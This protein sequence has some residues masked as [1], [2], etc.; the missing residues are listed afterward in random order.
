MHK[1]KKMKNKLLLLLVLFNLIVISCKKETKNEATQTPKIEENK[2][3]NVT[4]NL[5]VTVDDN[6]QIYYIED[7]S[8]IFTPDK[9]IDVS[10][11][12][13]NTPQEINFKLPE[14]VVP[15]NLR[16]DLGTN[17]Q[18]KEV[19]II[20]F[21]LKYYDKSF[22]SKDTMFVYYFW[23]NDQII[24]D[25]KKATATPKI[26]TNGNYDPIFVATDMLKKEILKLTK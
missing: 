8:N 14:D 11:K 17:K 18:Q 24:Y 16:F 2:S 20:D 15:T 1:L 3:F 6:F 22:V 12:G 25:R 5:V 26:S 19:K 13:K 4:M 7:D 10:I 9:Y 21:K 23:N